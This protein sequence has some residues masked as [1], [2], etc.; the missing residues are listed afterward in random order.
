MAVRRPDVMVSHVRTVETK[1]S[2]VMVK[3]VAT[4]VELLKDGASYVLTT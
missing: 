3:T 2:S 4:Q 1:V